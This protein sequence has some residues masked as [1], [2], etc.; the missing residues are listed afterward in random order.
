MRRAIC[1]TW[2]AFGPAVTTFGPSN[3]SNS[4][5][6][7]GPGVGASPVP[8]WNRHPVVGSAW[9]IPWWASISQQPPSRSQRN[10][11]STVTLM[12]S[13]SART[14]TTLVD[15]L[16]GR[17]FDIVYTGIGALG[18]LPRSPGVGSR[19]GRIASARRCSVFGRV[20]PVV[21]G[22]LSDGRTLQ[23]DIFEAAYMRWDEKGGTYAA[24]DARPRQ[25]NDV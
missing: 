10:S 7:R 24:P 23:Q 18:W 2:S 3:S 6:V 16:A 11:P 15:T 8:P 1:T 13:S 14:S 17:T 25:H 4:G 22:V 12:P 20:H 19:G 5:S 21:L 9:R